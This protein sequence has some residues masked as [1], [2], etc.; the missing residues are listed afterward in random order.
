MHTASVNQ[1]CVL[2]PASLT[3]RSVATT[4]DAILA[5]IEKSGQ[6][7]IDLPAEAQVDLSFVQLLESAR[8]HATSAGKQISLSRP[9]DGVLLDTLRRGGFLEGMTAEDAQFWLHQG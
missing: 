2:L 6:T 5:A 3:L 7:V 4:R 1:D 8:I 9:A